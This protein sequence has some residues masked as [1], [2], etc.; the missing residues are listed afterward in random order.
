[1]GLFHPKVA[2]DSHMK[3]FFHNIL[4]NFMRIAYSTNDVTGE[5]KSQISDNLSSFALLDKVV[6]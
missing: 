1:M 3:D 6:V 5:V 2:L 4:R